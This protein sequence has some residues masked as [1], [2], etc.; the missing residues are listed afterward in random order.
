MHL[1]AT[2]IEGNVIWRFYIF[3]DVNRKEVSQP[4][5]WPPGARCF[6]MELKRQIREPATVDSRE[7]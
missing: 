3:L 1:L 6:A 2:C 5:T 4:V 7:G